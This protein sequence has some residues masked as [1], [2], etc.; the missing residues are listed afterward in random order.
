[1][2]DLSELGKIWKEM[3]NPDKPGV[4]DGERQTS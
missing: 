2:D 4:D 1:M 3:V